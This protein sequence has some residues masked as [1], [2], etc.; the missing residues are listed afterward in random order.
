ME[1]DMT[2]QYILGCFVAVFLGFIALKILR[3]NGNKHMKRQTPKG[4]A[5]RPISDRAVP[6]KDGPPDVVIVG[7]GVAGSALAYSLAK[8]YIYI[9]V[10]VCFEYIF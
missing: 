2:E 7:A 4:A 8:V 6:A 10:C 3:K 9:C 5:V 1:L